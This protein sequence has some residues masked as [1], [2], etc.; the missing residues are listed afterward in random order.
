MR[1]SPVERN[2]PLHGPLVCACVRR[3][4]CLR[5]LFSSS[6]CSGTA[7]TLDAFT[8]GA[9]MAAQPNQ[10]VSRQVGEAV[11]GRVSACAWMRQT[12]SAPC[13]CVSEAILER[14]GVGAR[15]T[16]GVGVE[17]LQHLRAYSMTAMTRA[18]STSELRC[19]GEIAAD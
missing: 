2:C 8:F 4:V 7:F 15:L 14:A 19:C 3:C 6:D 1:Q 18:H 11:H 10:K 17:A 16:D 13:K 5:T 9:R 12:S